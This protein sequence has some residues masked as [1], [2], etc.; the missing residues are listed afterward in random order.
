MASVSLALS[1]ASTKLKEM[2]VSLS[3]T[4]A[5]LASTKVE[6]ST[7]KEELV[8]YKKT[9]DALQA[10]IKTTEE[11]ERNK[12]ISE[13]KGIDP[14]VDINFVT[15]MSTV[16]LSAYKSNIDRIASRGIAA[17][18]RKSVKADEQVTLS[19]VETAP[20]TRHDVASGIVTHLGK[21]QI[22][23]NSRFGM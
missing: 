10:Q 6:L 22:A 9:V 15:S 1:E 19:A 16:Q 18:G 4:R 7:T 8:G 14:E 17:G 3:S 5:E 23:K 11:A 21:K 2:E 12:L 13:I 20:I